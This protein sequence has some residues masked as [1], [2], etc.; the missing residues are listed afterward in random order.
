MKDNMQLKNRN[1]LV[2]VAVKFIY[3]K[4]DFLSDRKL[5]AIT[6][7]YKKFP[8]LLCWSMWWGQ[9]KGKRPKFCPDLYDWAKQARKIQLFGTNLLVSYG[10]EKL[11]SHRD[12]QVSSLITELGLSWFQ[13]LILKCTM[14]LKTSHW[15]ILKLFD[16]EKTLVCKK[17]NKVDTRREKKWKIKQRPHIP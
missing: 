3:I 5:E 1:F 14:C 10:L 15:V 7:S 8:H 13:I 11:K 12:S 16:R 9:L 17:M 6:S 4:Q 2:N